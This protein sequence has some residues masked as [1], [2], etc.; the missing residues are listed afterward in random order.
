MFL[1]WYILGRVGK[2]DPCAGF[3]D[4]VLSSNAN[5]F[6]YL[7]MAK[8]QDNLVHQTAAPYRRQIPLWGVALR[9]CA[10]AVGLRRPKVRTRLC[11]LRRRFPSGARGVCDILG[12]GEH[13]SE[14]APL[15]QGLGAGA[16]VSGSPSRGACW[17]QDPGKAG[18]SLRESCGAAVP[19]HSAA[20]PL[21]PTFLPRV[22]TGGPAWLL[23]LRCSPSRSYARRPRGLWSPWTILSGQCPW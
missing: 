6:F 16:S 13:S 12:S 1:F 4:G 7:G 3:G 20:C 2:E 23:H 11:V 19:G 21:P 22:N 9:P 18:R 5:S 15:A 14:T 17:D 10:C 8:G